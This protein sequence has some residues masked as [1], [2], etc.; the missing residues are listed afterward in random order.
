MEKAYSGDVGCIFMPGVLSEGMK[1]ATGIQISREEPE[2]LL[3]GKPD[4][5]T[6][7]GKKKPIFI[8]KN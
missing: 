4:D 1:M 5:I 8:S 3:I 6:L 2:L 7:I